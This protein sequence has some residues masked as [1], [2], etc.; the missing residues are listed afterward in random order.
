MKKVLVTWMV[1]SGKNRFAVFNLITATYGELKTTTAYK[2]NDNII[3]M[4]EKGYWPKDD[5]TYFEPSNLGDLTGWLSY[6][7][8]RFAKKHGLYVFFV[9]GVKPCQ[10]YVKRGFVQE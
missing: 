4:G 2:N 1:Y 7:Q 9:K 6:S 10:K 8:S 3:D 5:F